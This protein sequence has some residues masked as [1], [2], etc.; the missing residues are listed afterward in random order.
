MYQVINNVE[1]ADQEK[2]Y[3]LQREKYVNEEPNADS[4]INLMFFISSGLLDIEMAFNRNFSS[5]SKL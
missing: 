5:E 4:T 1:E 2:I 3:I